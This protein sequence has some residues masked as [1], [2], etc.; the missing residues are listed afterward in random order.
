MSAI[1]FKIFIANYLRKFSVSKND[2]WW[3]QVIKFENPFNCPTLSPIKT[4]SSVIRQNQ[5]GIVLCQQAPEISKI[6][7]LIVTCLS[8]SFLRIVKFSSI[9]RLLLCV[10]NVYIASIRF[11]CFT[12]L[13]VIYLCRS[14]H[15]VV[16]LK[17]CSK[18]A[19]NKS[20]FFRSWVDEVDQRNWRPFFFWNS[21]ECYLY[22]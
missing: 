4:V 19:L 11:S 10:V 13:N 17:C 8:R 22:K 16:L 5:C 9:H 21:A 2:H 18:W 12:T 7:L 3:F 20:G 6:L 14:L 15:D 1:Y